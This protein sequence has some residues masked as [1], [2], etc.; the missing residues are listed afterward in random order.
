MITRKLVRLEP[1]EERPK[2]LSDPG[3]EGMREETDAELRERIRADLERGRFTRLVA[4][5]VIAEIDAGLL[6]WEEA[7]AAGRIP[8]LLTEADVRA[9]L[10]RGDL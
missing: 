7:L 2:S 5:T 4:A 10:A 9:E 8:H 3:I 1:G 6:T